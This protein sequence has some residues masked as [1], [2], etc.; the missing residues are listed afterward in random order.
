M[1]DEESTYS[2][3]WSDAYFKEKRKGDRKKKIKNIFNLWQV[4]NG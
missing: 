3:Q 2:K 1:L 4:K